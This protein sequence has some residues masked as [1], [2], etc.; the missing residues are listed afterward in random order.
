M[1]LCELMLSR[2]GCALFFVAS[3]RFFFPVPYLT[4]H[5]AQLRS[6]VRH[7]YVDNMSLMI[8]A[9]RVAADG[10]SY[11]LVELSTAH[12]QYDGLPCPARQRPADRRRA[13]FT[14]LAARTYFFSHPAVP[15]I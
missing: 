13:S 1:K 10:T 7:N 4:S 8:Y 14:R 6:L 11:Y 12:A 5:A 2:C 9:M 15:L 3:A